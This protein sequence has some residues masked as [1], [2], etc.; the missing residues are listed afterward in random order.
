M[1]ILMVCNYSSGISGVW[2]RVLEEAK[3]FIKQG[4][5]VYVFSSDQQENGEKELSTQEILDVRLNNGID[6]ERF[7]IKRKVGYAIWFDFE[8]EALNLKP[9]VIIAHGLRKPYLNKVLKIK[10]KIGCKAFLITHAPF[11]DKEL[12]S[13]KTNFII[14]LYDTFFGKKIMNSFDKIISICRWEKEILLKLGCKE[15]KIVYLPNSLSEEFFNKEPISEEKKI[16]YL[17]RMNPVKE[18]ELLIEAFKE[19]NSSSNGYKLE[20]V[21]SNEGE[22]YK[23]LFSISNKNVIF[24]EPIYDLN[25]KIEKIDSAEIFVLPSK[26]ESLP[27]GIIEAMSRGK[28]V[29]ATNTKGALELIEDK[30]NG[31]LF[32]IGDKGGLIGILNNKLSEK[33]KK[34]IGQEAKKSSQEFRISNVMDKWE[35]LFK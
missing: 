24:T 28:I 15:D 2:T 34:Q 33:R 10:K 31:F 17:G 16:L 3:E 9:D 19:S 30:K 29:I 14:F 11:V 27:F 35:E 21:S 5:E 22:Y 20:I 25:K 18:I 23:K 32:D 13:W 6:I 26:K 8:K 1:K 7:P 4:H 12:R